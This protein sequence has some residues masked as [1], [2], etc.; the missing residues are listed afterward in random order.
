MSFKSIILTSIAVLGLLLSPLQTAQANDG[1]YVSVWGGYFYT[2][3]PEVEGFSQ[4]LVGGGF[5]LIQDFPLDAEEGGFF[6]A[7]FGT[8]I[9]PT[10][11]FFKHIEVY[12]EGL[13]TEK[14][15]QAFADPSGITYTQFGFSDGIIAAVIPS[16]AS[17]ELER[18]RYEFGANLS[19]GNQMPNFG[20]L[21]LVATVFGGFGNEDVFVH[22]FIPGAGIFDTSKSDLDWQFYGLLLGTDATIPVSTSLDLILR[23]AAGIYYFDADADFVSTSDFASRN[24]QTSDSDNDFGFRGKLSAELRAKLSQ[25]IVV[26]LFGGVDYWS[27]VPYSELT[28]SSTFLFSTGVPA[29]IDTDD[30]LDV[31]AGIKVTVSLDGNQ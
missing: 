15:K 7:S 23:G 25:D 11:L 31:K 17:A 16:V 9:D 1:T 29:H 6:G 14:D 26:S 28:D 13:I 27:D 10:S 20:P 30:V 2:D 24:F 22:H 5:P 8:P 3:A 18:E 12:F 21:N 4:N 19:L